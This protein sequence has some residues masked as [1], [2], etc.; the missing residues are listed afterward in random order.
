MQKYDCIFIAQIYFCEEECD[1]NK[2][3]LSFNEFWFSVI[4]N[5]TLVLNY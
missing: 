1:L 2:I 5:Y 4:C 3:T